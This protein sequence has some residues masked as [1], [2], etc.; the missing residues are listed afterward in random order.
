MTTERPSTETTTRTRGHNGGTSRSGATGPDG[1]AAL[2]GAVRE[3]RGALEGVGRSMPELARASRSAM[4]DAMRAIE[5]GSDER[6]SAGVTLT[7]GLAIGLLIG[8]AP[9]LF[10]ALALIPLAAMGLT[11]IDRRSRAGR[12]GNRS[13]TAA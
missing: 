2:E 13:A 5:S 12:A 11:M 6:L 3:A 1:R 10:I 8:G 7:L 4:D 9:R